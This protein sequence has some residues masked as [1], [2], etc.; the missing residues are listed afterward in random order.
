MT[1]DGASIDKYSDVV[2]AWRDVG[3]RV[4]ASAGPQPLDKQEVNR[5]PCRSMAAT[6]S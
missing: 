6:M 1:D 3:K 2:P 4:R 5:W